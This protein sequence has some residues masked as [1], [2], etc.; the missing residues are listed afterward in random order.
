M[1]YFGFSIGQVLQTWANMGVFA[2]LL[3]FL[4]IF[5]I[6]FGILNKS[7]LLGENKGVQ[8][9]IAMAVGLLALQFDYVANFYATIFPYAGVGLSIILVSLIFLGFVSGDTKMENFKKWAWLI[10][11]IIIFIIVTFTSLTR[12]IWFGGLGYGITDSLPAIIAI[13]LLV[14]VIYAIIKGGKSS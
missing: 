12:N 2:Y 14:G 1:A 7:N 10:I 4:M 9:T 3:P 6:V 11:G 5:A 8:A 13:L